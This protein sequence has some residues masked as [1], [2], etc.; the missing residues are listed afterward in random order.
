M[1]R[2]FYPLHSKSKFIPMSIFCSDNKTKKPGAGGGIGSMLTQVRFY[3]PLTFKNISL[4]N[5]KISMTFVLDEI[6]I[7]VNTVLIL[8]ISYCI[9]WKSKN[10]SIPVLQT[11]R[12]F[13]KCQCSKFATVF[14]TICHT[15][16][17]D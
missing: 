11:V 10:N 9:F 8:P 5:L 3:Q 13:N 1:T 15:L 2:I 4:F 7:N 12:S 6:E 17:S 14:A 16:V